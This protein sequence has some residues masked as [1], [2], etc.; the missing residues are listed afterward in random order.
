MPP[1]RMAASL[2]P[3][4]DRRDPARRRLDVARALS[5]QIYSYE[6][7]LERRRTDTTWPGSAT[8]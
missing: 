8:N 1:C 3:E 6:A 2:Q 4:M 5:G 7:T